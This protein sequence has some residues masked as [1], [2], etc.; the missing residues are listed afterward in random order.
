MSANWLAKTARATGLVLWTTVAFVGAQVAIAFLMEGLNAW[1]PALA[2]LNDAVYMTIYAACSYVLAVAVAVG[3]PW[4]LKKR[5]SKKELGVEHWPLWRDIG[6]GAGGYV[7][8][9]L[10][11][12]VL[13]TIVTYLHGSE[14][15]QAQDIPFSGLA[16]QFEFIVAFIT[17]VVLA[18]LAEELL[19][20]GYL[21]G[22]LKT[23]L[24]A[25]L[26]IG[27]SALVFGAMHLPGSSGLQWMV[28][29][30]TFTLG[31]VVGFLRVRTGSIWAGVLIHAFKNALAFYFLFIN[32]TILGML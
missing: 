11:S 21:L 25:W 32:P 1:L 14:L 12:V 2:S 28:A 27:I 7:V 9:F 4:W 5:T 15:N 23:F 18:P 22:K 19:F 17:L 20:R 8:Y 24:P 6:F 26:A 16:L 13:A 29:I 10:L 31:I 30:D 3:V